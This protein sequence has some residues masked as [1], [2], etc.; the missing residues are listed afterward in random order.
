MIGKVMA[1]NSNGELQTPSLKVA[2]GSVESLISMPRCVLRADEVT[3]FQ[4]AAAPLRPFVWLGRLLT[5]V[6]MW[7]VYHSPGVMTV[8]GLLAVFGTWQWL[9][10]GDRKTFYTLYLHTHIP[11]HPK[12]NFYRTFSL[13][14]LAIVLD[15]ISWALGDRPRECTGRGWDKEHHPDS[16][17]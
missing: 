2:K 15:Q 6:M 8:A 16:F 1:I 12:I 17:S 11:H 13:F 14:E 10:A 7:A 4:L 5:P 9:S 3:L